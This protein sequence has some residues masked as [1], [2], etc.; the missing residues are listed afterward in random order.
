MGYFNEAN[1]ANMRATLALGR[2]HPSLYDAY[3]DQPS[4]SE[5]YWNA[6]RGWVAQYDAWR[7]ST[8]EGWRQIMT[9]QPV[10]HTI[11]AAPQNS[12]G[13]A[14]NIDV[15]RP[16][17]MD[18][19]LYGYYLNT[20]KAA[21]QGALAEIAAAA[22]VVVDWTRFQVRAM[23]HEYDDQVA[24]GRDPMTIFSH[25]QPFSD[26]I[27]LP[28]RFAGEELGNETLKRA[29]AGLAPGTQWY[30]D[31]AG[32]GDR[33]DSARDKARFNRFVLVAG[34]L[35]TAGY[36]STIG[37]GAG[38]AASTGGT[39]VAE[40]AAA[41]GIAQTGSAAGAAAGAS[42][43]VAAAS[44]AEEAAALGIAEVSAAPAAQAGAASAVG[45]ALEQVG[46][47]VVKAGTA[48]VQQVGKAVLGTAAAAVVNELGPEQ[49]KAPAPQPQGAQASSS[50]VLG[51]LM[52][53][54][55]A[56]AALR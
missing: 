45:G 48:L 12:S 3:N 28:V 26:L 44:V 38:T 33:L 46:A 32:I 23:K 30:T 51:L 34:G 25:S 13:D 41:L 52:V 40:E 31:H 47:Q 15:W 55:A 37:V 17:S 8:A 1:I 42:S 7:A 4:I 36:L 18:H 19:L 54:V 21:V 5:G 16:M 50:P 9:A 10:W 56:L 43:G 24:H 39:V 53:G 35:L 6:M 14:G 29:A 20:H 2:N 27:Y 49:P 22:G 11:E